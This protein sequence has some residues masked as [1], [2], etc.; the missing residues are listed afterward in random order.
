MKHDSW[1]GDSFPSSDVD[2][3]LQNV[4]YVPLGVVENGEAGDDFSDD[5]SSEDEHQGYMPL[6]VE[7]GEEI[8]QGEPQQEDFVDGNVEEEDFE[9]EFFSVK[10]KEE[11]TIIN[12]EASQPSPETLRK[13]E[14]ALKEFDER[15]ASLL[16]SLSS[17]FVSFRFLFCPDTPK[18]C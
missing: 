7:D 13:N 12:S 8:F 18:R 4:E 2:E 3:E 17:F 14:Q 1:S 15:F 6:N 9:E 11:K 16:F 10:I 5:D